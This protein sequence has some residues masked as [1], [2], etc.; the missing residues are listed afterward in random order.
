MSIPKE[1]RQLM[2]N[3]MYLVLMALLALNVSA[4]IFKAFEKVDHSLERS[5]ASLVDVNS[6]LPDALR[7]AAKKDE[8][9]DKYVNQLDGLKQTSSAFVS[10]VQDLEDRLIDEAG[11]RDGKHTKEQEGDY[12]MRAGHWELKGKKDK[13]VTTRLLVGDVNDDTDGWGDELKAKILEAREA[14]STYISEVID[15][16]DPEDKD[17]KNIDQIIANTVSLDIAE[18]LDAVEHDEEMKTWAQ[19]NFNQMPLAATM[20]IFEKLRNDAIAT[21]NAILN[22]Y[23]K[24]IGT[25]DD[26]VLSEFQVVSSPEKTYVISGEQFKTKVFLSASAGATSRAGVS[27]RVNGQ[28]LPVNNGVAEYAARASGTGVKKYNAAITVTNPVTGK[29]ET[30]EETFEYEVG[31]R[32]ATVSADKMNVFYIGVENPITVSVAGV[33]WHTVKVSTGGSGGV[34]LKANG[35]GKYIA[36]ASRVTKLNDDAQII[37]S[38][39]GLA[40][41]KFP[42]RVKRIPDPI[43]KLG[44]TRLEGTIGNGEFKAQ[45]GIIP[46][47]EGFDFNA[48]CNIEGFQIVRLPRNADPIPVP[49]R[50][51]TYSGEAR[52]LAQEAKPG[53]TYFIENVRCKCP[54]DIASRKLN[55]MVFKI[56]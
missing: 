9:F 35:K 18:D 42:F 11:D 21:E 30:Y 34:K 37:V 12:V 4:K 17:S 46:T 14:F 19:Y 1:P 36:T 25:S 38:G 20:P 45:R 32:G 41:T 16:N 5:N 8:K 55:S 28:S 6:K 48:K 40:A 43:A 7:K 10:Y 27:V 50:G 3:L 29:S 15:A 26:I 47:L 39:E 49:N 51:G 31:I 2:I 54:G 33:P 56:K 13:A 53:D 22:Y 24:R 52:R 23:A 44:G